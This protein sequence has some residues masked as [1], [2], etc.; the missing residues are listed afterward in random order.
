MTY[1][2]QIKRKNRYETE[3]RRGVGGGGEWKKKRKE[4]KGRLN[5]KTILK[6]ETL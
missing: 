2:V 4:K 3:Q 5:S 6:K 1:T